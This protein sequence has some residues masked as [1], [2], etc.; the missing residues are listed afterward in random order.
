MAWYWIILIVIGY[1]IVGS[2]CAGLTNRIAELAEGDYLDEDC[3]PIVVFFWPL[4]L[5]LL[6]V[7]YMC[8]YIIKLFNR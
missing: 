6:L 3:V 1:L 7:V 4:A 2:V 5:P 8:D